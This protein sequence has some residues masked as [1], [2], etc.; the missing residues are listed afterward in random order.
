MVS[1]RGGPEN[2]GT[3]TV[4][5]R[6]PPPISPHG[7]LPDLPVMFSFP[8]VIFSVRRSDARAAALRLA[9]RFFVSPFEVTNAEFR[10][11]LIDAKGYADD[12]NWTEAGRKWKST[13]AFTRLLPGSRDAFKRFMASLIS[14]W[15]R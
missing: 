15:S 3:F 13:N 14:H 12:A 11:F 6:P 9:R 4:T 8:A 10:E 2:E 5:I 7:L 1:Y